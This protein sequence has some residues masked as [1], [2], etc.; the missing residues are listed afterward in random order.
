[1]LAL[2]PN[3]AEVARE[4]HGRWIEPD[5]VEHLMDGLRKAGWRLLQ[6]RERKPRRQPRPVLPRSTQ[7]RF[8]PKKDSGWRCCHL[9]IAAATPTSWAWQKRLTEEI[10]TGLSRFSYLKVIALG[11][12][13]RYANE[14]VDVRSA[15]KE[16]GARYVM[17]GSLRQA[18]TRLR[19]AVQLVDAVSGAHI[20][21]ENYERTFSPE[22]VFELQDDL[23][24]R[25]VS[26]VA[27]QYGALVH[28]MSELLRGRSAWSI[29]RA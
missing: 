6:R 20:W 23:V 28:S 17:E 8:A 12:T 22:T 10:V 2:K 14:S 4:L 26:T 13:A 15:G 7:A 25:I 29:L 27:D 9:S 24:P 18:G 1:M 11:S 19:L 5:L 21:A 3:Y 16:L